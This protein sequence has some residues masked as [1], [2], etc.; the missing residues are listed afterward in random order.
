VEAIE[1]LTGLSNW[2]VQQGRQVVIHDG[3]AEGTNNDATEQVVVSQSSFA[4]VAVNPPS[5]TTFLNKFKDISE[6]ISG[7]FAKKLNYQRLGAR[8]VRYIPIAIA[9]PE[10]V[11]RFHEKYGRPEVTALFPTAKRTDIGYSVD[12]LWDRATLHTTCGPMKKQQAIGTHFQPFVNSEQLNPWSEVGIFFDM[13][14]YQTADVP[15]RLID[16][17]ILLKKFLEEQDAAA[18]RIQNQYMSANVPA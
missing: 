8:S 1:E 4:Y 15:S 7:I 12:Y 18:K 13:D 14:F 10:L 9:F 16:I 5:T 2:I 17:R 3:A 6:K 11:E